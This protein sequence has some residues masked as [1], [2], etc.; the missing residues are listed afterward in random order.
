MP[1]IGVFHPQIV[2][3]VVGL[4]IVGVGA[5]VLS[6]VAGKRLPWLSPMA[7]TLIVLGTIAALAAFQSGIQAHGVVERIP[8]TREAVEEHQEAGEWTRNVFLLVAVLELASVILGSRRAAAGLR[9][10][11]AV[12]G[13]VGLAVIYRTA[14]FGG[15]VVYAYAGGVGT[16]SGDTTDVRRLLVAGLYQNAQL[17]RRAGR[18]DEAARLTD[19]LAR[20]RPNDPDVHFLAIESQLLDRQDARGALAELTATKVRDDDRRMQM[21]RATLMVQAY[22]AVG[23]M[24]SAHAVI[25]D[26]ERRFP[27]DPRVKQTIERL[28]GGQSSR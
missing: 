21:R 12:I 7:T 4:L 8:G 15:R 1:N 24:D 22:R 23:A 2:H 11:S 25:A 20:Q 17:A 6:L 16:R 5:R 27:N 10:A 13:L 19:E 3:F 18:R 26:L 14:E 28:T 9:I